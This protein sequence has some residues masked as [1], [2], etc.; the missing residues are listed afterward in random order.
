M[1]TTAFAAVLIAGCYSGHNES[2]EG[3]TD[4][5]GTVDPSEGEAGETGEP[6][7]VECDGEILDPGPNLTRRLTV[8][9]YGNTVEALLGVDVRAE[10]EAELPAELRADGFTNTASGLITTLQH[11]EAYDELA[12]LAVSRIP[13]LSAFA[14]L[15]TSCLD[16]EDNCKSEFVQNLGSTAFRRPP[17]ADEADLLTVVFDIAQDEGMG[18]EVGAGLVIETMLQSPPFLYRLEDETAGNV[19]RELD[20]YEMA[21]RLSYLL[22]AGPPDDVLLAAA[23]SDSLGSDAEIEAEVER[24]LADPQA[25]EASVGFV[26]DWLHLA[27]LTNLPRDP[28]R[29]PDWSSEIS[30]AM[31]AETIEFFNS[32]VWDQE[33]SLTDLFVAQEAWLTPEL[34]AYYGIESEGEGLVQYDVSGIPERGGLFTQGALLT[35]GGDDASMV[36][37]GLFLFENVL[38]QH[39]QSPPEG[40][41]TTPPVIEPGKSQRFYSEERT[42]NPSCAG[43]HLQFE[44]AAWGLERFLAD[45][46]YALTDSFGNDLREDGEMQL[47]GEA[48]TLPFNTA[49]EMMQ[50]LADNEAVRECFGK[51]GTQF[52]ISRPLMESDDCSLGR[53]QEA[54]ETSDGSWRDLIVAIALSPGFRSIRVES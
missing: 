5:A 10:A 12:E 23:A 7:P 25:R 44:P 34:A 16:Y 21:S 46:S 38:C 41:D 9:E 50:L 37:R 54:L 31:D 24:M 6:P 29:F 17:T 8:R 30:A 32:V 33:R 49:G 11:V 15:Y 35:I 42:T 2:P 43:C 27:R 14:S 20:G 40:I 39:P 1:T 52:A 47:P 48:G 51:K 26:R 13:N 45:G 53:V 28:D 4:S 22:W 3:D 18:F 36:A 19:V